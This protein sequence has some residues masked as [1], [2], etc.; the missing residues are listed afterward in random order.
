[1][2]V[3]TRVLKGKVQAGSG[4]RASGTGW[5]IGPGL[6][7]TNH[8]VIEARDLKFETPADESD[9]RAQ[10]ATA[11]IWFDYQEDEARHWDYGGWELAHT[12]RSLD[13]A[14]LRSASDPDGGSSPLSDWGFLP[15]VPE[16][17]ELTRGARL[18]IIQHPQGGPK[19][20]AIRSN[21][22]FDGYSTA[23]EPDRLRYLTD[24]EPGSSG[25]PVFGD[26]WRVLALHH[27][28]V[29]IPQE[30]YRG[31]VIKYN[32]QG[33]AITAILNDLPAP[34]R[35]EIQAAQGWS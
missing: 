11:N 7:M 10:A 19:R 13:Y 29:A 6:L 31:E 8:H 16:L 14:L 26:D 4:S 28:A 12:S 33:I 23:Q 18:N 21:F 2:V 22:Y 1:M 5:M 24:T 9:F 20:I 3:I 27:A 35:Q 34:I 32:N 25:S 17:P 30:T 15:V